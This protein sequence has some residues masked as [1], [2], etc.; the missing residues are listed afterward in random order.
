MRVEGKGRKLKQ[1]GKKTPNRYTHL[2][3]NQIFSYILPLLS[4]QHRYV[5]TLRSITQG[6][7]EFC[8]HCSCIR[9][10]TY[11][12]LASTR[13]K[14]VAIGFPV[15]HTLL[16]VSNRGRRSKTANLAMA[17]KLATKR[18]TSLHEPSDEPP[19]PIVMKS[20]CCC[21]TVDVRCDA[22]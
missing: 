17:A 1:I 7:A 15:P 22:G 2:N 3:S 16:L 19:E 5:R 18:R 12:S 21:C 11:A 4:D 20:T 6:W 8:V 13:Y 9:L 14:S 10:R